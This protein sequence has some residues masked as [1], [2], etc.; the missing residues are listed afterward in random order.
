[1][2]SPSRIDSGLPVEPVPSSFTPSTSI[3]LTGVQ[4]ALTALKSALDHSH[5]AQSFYSISMGSPEGGTFPISNGDGTVC[6][7]TRNDASLWAQ[8]Y[9]Q[10]GEQYMISA[11]N[12]MA[13]YHDPTTYINVPDTRF[14]RAVS[15]TK[16][17]VENETMNEKARRVA[18]DWM[19]TQTDLATSWIAAL[20]SIH[21][22][23]AGDWELKDE[24][25]TVIYTPM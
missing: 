1:M 4:R 15:V 3:A 12:E 7:Y 17:A 9:H 21:T 2:S 8:T 25:R 20:S 14:L 13:T 6:N 24:L 16:D 19:G 22:L 11:L 23:P 5:M 18:L 10:S